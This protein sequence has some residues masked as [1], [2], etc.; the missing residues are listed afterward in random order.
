M[1]VCWPLTNIVFSWPIL[2]VM[3]KTRCC[4][5]DDAGVRKIKID[6]FF[7]FSVGS[8]VGSRIYPGLRVSLYF[9]CN[10][11]KIFNFPR[12]CLNFLNKNYANLK[13]SHF[14]FQPKTSIVYISQIDTRYVGKKL[15]ITEA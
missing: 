8:R 7:T 12:F 13:Q 6:M 15:K 4:D 10:K 9:T 1:F 11:P 5:D 2:L 14:R 3:S